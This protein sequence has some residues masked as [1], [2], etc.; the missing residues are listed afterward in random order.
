MQGTADYRGA[1]KKA[2]NNGKVRGTRHL[3]GGRLVVQRRLWGQRLKLVKESVGLTLVER[4]GRK[5]G[6]AGS[7]KRAEGRR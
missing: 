6:L 3:Q 5:S 7:R 1:S 2:Q 4:G